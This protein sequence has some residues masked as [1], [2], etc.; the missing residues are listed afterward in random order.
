MFDT[1]SAATA[2]TRTEWH[3]VIKACVCI[4]KGSGRGGSAC[5]W[6]GGWALCYSIYILIHLIIDYLY[7]F[8]QKTP[9]SVLW[10]STETLHRGTIYIHVHFQPRA[11]TLKS[12]HLKEV[13]TRERSIKGTF[14][15]Q[16]KATSV[17]CSAT[18]CSKLSLSSGISIQKR[19]PCACLCFPNHSRTGN[20]TPA[21][22]GKQTLL[23]HFPQL[24]ADEKFV[25]P[26][27]VLTDPALNYV[28]LGAVTHWWV[29]HLIKSELAVQK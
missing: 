9:V 1:S 25:L 27:L 3:S 29:M 2:G 8:S 23:F 11:H 17:C 20:Q 5:G 12:R 26:H 4:Q 13:Y 22:R 19:A 16:S 21:F 7:S 14:E 24:G 18:D 15:A 6:G 10:S 28:S